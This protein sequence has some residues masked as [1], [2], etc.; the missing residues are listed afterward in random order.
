MGC[1]FDSYELVVAR[2]KMVCGSESHELV[3]ASRKMGREFES[4][5]LV[6]ASCKMMYSINLSMKYY[7]PSSSL[8]SADD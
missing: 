4:Y 1:R 3:V 5:E 6:V 8:P 7:A 2:C